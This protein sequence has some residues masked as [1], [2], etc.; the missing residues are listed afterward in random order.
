MLFSPGKLFFKK[1]SYLYSKYSNL[2][3]IMHTQIHKTFSII[4]QLIDIG[5]TSV[6]GDLSLKIKKADTNEEFKFIVQALENER[7]EDARL[8]IEDYERQTKQLMVHFDPFVSALKVELFVQENQLHNLSLELEEILK[9]INTFHINYHHNLGP[10]LVRLLHLRKEKLRLQAIDNPAMQAQYD[11]ALKEYEEYHDI[12]TSPVQGLFHNLNE[13]QLR[14]LKILYRKASM[15]CHPDRVVAEMKEEAQ[16]MF[17]ELHEAYQQ[18]DLKKVR[19]MAQLLEKTGRFEPMRLHLDNAEALRSQINLIMVHIDEKNL[20][21]EEVKTSPAFKKVKD[22]GNDWS[23]YFQLLTNNFKSQIE[24]LE[25]W[26][27][28]YSNQN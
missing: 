25:R 1:F 24:T 16:D 17:E 19:I 4:K 12:H 14:E 5:D 18:N 11:E 10:L 2:L 27:L 15:L 7:F 22:L 23:E 8:L 9:G 3:I 20:Q 6:I 21:L 28:T 26:H 13:E